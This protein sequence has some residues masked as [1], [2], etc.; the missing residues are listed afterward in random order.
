[1]ESRNLKLWIYKGN[2]EVQNKV[3]SKMVRKVENTHQPKRQ[4]SGRLTGA[5]QLALYKNKIQER[6]TTYHVAQHTREGIP[7]S[8][9]FF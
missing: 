4:V 8:Y 5:Y 1:M 7:A 6:Q 2:N 3:L 9:S